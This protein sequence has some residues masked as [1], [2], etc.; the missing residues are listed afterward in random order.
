MEQ[1]KPLSSTVSNK[2]KGGGALTD[3]VI[4]LPASTCRNGLSFW[5]DYSPV[6]VLVHVEIDGIRVSATFLR[7][8]QNQSLQ[9]EERNSESE[10]L[11]ELSL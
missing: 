7:N 2:K 3:D 9:N 8:K 10:S 6:I 11:E 1:L 5:A 4:A